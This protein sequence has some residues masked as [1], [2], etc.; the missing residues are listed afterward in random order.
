MKHKRIAALTAAS[1]LALS[2]FSYTGTAFAAVQYKDVTFS[3]L[4][5]NGGEA[6]AGVDISSVIALEKSGVVFKDKDGN[7]QDIFLT[8]K[9][10]GVNYIRVRIWNKPET[11]SGVTYG[12]GANDI[13]TAVEIAKRCSKYGLKLLVDF[14][15][16]DF[17]A[18]PGKQKA[19]K[20]WANYSVDQKCSAISSF[21]SDSLKKLKATGAEIGMVQVGNETTTGLCGE[22]DW[23]N[24]C[25]LMNAGSKAVRQFDKNI[26]VAVHFTNPEKSGNYEWLAGNLKTY[27]VDYDV[28][29]SSY[30]PYW[31]GTPQNLTNVL[32]NIA[33]KYNKYVIVAETSW[34][35][36]FED[37]DNFANT[38][39]DESSLGNYVSYPVSVQ[40]QTDA[41]TN[42]FDA[43][44]KIGPKGIG[45][46][47]WE[48]AW[49][50]VG[51]N[52]EHNLSL[53]E[54]DG[55][56]WATKASGEYDEDGGKWFGGSSVDNQ[57][58]FSQDGRPLDSLY[59]YS[60]IKSDKNTQPEEQKDNLL[61][62]PG[63]ED[64]DSGWK[65]ENTT[66]GEY[67]KF[68]VNGEMT[69]TGSYAAHWYSANAFQYTGL[70]AEYTAPET[71]S[72]VFTDWLAGEKTSYKTMISINGSAVKDDTGSVTSYDNWQESTV[73]F[74]AQKGDTIG[75]WI[76]LNG[77][78]GGYGSV[79][80]CE[81]YLKKQASV[82]SPSP[83]PTVSPAPQSPEP[84]NTPDPGPSPE[85][86][87]TTD[88]ETPPTL[89]SIDDPIK[90][91]I[92]EDRK[93]NA[94]DLIV[95][96]SYM[97]NT[98]SFSETEAKQADMDYNEKINIIDL[99]YLKE[100]ILDGTYR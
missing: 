35:N 51:D 70:Y 27:G 78:A 8:L 21:T 10:A 2:C 52:Y 32:G 22:K 79:D 76:E 34:A 69:R 75:I 19:P 45:A 18:D 65:L 14:H 57:A 55:S 77:E 83:E 91:D 17:W 85:P 99:L 15:Y 61:D 72:Y 86:T 81:L 58:L 82:P 11:N 60:H 13:N 4:T 33:R 44:A 100:R 36:T 89:V 71:G 73:E 56:G 50:T 96:L 94:S 93:V 25:A 9:D 95:L 64:G 92:N 47:Y 97:Q 26:L 39:G 16:S 87:P 20:E 66:T 5:V 23:K 3:G 31:H 24:I 67:A 42:V 28:F 1:V 84:A 63:F 30:Y 68:E 7:P 90:G 12:G 98:S 54:R 80:D 29:A 59:V 48:P 53:W 6:I 46:F 40:G 49:I 38:I 43:V 37:S 74:S 62:N 41:L 88:P